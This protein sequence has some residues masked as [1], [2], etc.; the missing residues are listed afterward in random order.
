MSSQNTTYIRSRELLA[1]D[2]SRVLLVD[3][4]GKLTAIM[5][6]IELPIAN[7]RKLLLGARILGVPVSA[8][9]QYPR[10][11]GPTVPEL[12][13]LV[14]M[15][16]EKQRFSS[17]ECFSW[18]TEDK[19]DRVKV[20]VIGIDAHVCIQQTVLDLLAAGFSVYVPADAV[21]SRNPADRDV[22]LQRMRDSGATVTTTE[23]V[24]FEWCETAAAPEFKQIS[25]L[26]KGA[27]VDGP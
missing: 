19:G 11:L 12:A 17:A 23:S 16:V 5:P 6:G 13:E 10:G 25:A 7:C 20:V 8:T 14:E 18:V 2:D 1:R 15:R 27:M 24:L 3:V 26:I 21:A 9:E 4:Q 22:A